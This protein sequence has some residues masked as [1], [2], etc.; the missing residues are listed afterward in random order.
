MS[1]ETLQIDL[2]ERGGVQRFKSPD[3]VRAW[4]V[5]ELESWKWLA[6]AEGDDN[7]GLWNYVSQRFAWL[8][9]QLNGSLNS[10]HP[11]SNQNH[12]F[13]TVFVNG[14]ELVLHSEG[15]LGRR[16]QDIYAGH[17]G[18][19]G[20]AAYALATRRAG[21]QQ[22][23]HVEQLTGAMM[24]AAPSLVDSEAISRRL[25][26]ERRNLRDRT[27]RLVESLER[28]AEVRNEE[29]RN[30]RLKGRRVAVEWARRRFARWREQYEDAFSAAA[31]AQLEFGDAR[32]R[33]EKEFADLKAAFLEAMRLQAPAHYWQEKSEGHATAEKKAREKLLIFFPIALLGLGIAFGVTGYM[34]LT[35][36]PTGNA[37]AVYVVISGGLATIA[38]VVFWIGRLL[39]KL[40]LSEHHLR[41]DA[42][43]RKI[44]T[45]TYLA[46]TKE[47]AAEEA[48]RQIILAALF[49]NTP[50]G[51]VRDDG[52]A[53]NLS[54]LLSR[55]GMPGK[56]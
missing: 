21:I 40:Y 25:A 50:D 56:N 44:M 22:M 39:T 16:V 37:T 55:F 48:D 51:I 23:N 35:R 11:L 12:L 46:L 7:F 42:E 19:A 14:S 26:T 43:E 18:R 38:G 30:D 32:G 4:I 1:N 49:R 10:G 52:P 47:K 13:T 8:R 34:I 17:G 41:I 24:L 3:A 28:E 31:K 20:R 54:M 36:P 27:E 6:D 5:A 29:F 9:D 33:T 45:T 15:D 2:G 53:E